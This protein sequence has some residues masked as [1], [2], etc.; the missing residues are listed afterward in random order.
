MAIHVLEHLPNLPKALTE[1]HRSI[2]KTGTFQV[3]IPFERGFAYQIAR[4]ISA[5]RIFQS[6]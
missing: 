6:R 4:E 2:K 5:K 3:V 1:V